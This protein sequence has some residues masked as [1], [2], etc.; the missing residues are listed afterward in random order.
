MGFYASF[1]SIKLISAFF[2]ILKI[3]TVLRIE[4]L[5]HA[6]RERFFLQNPLSSVIFRPD[7]LFMEPMEPSFMVPMELLF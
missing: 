1:L 4:K 7:F 5:Q 3:D 6:R 2:R